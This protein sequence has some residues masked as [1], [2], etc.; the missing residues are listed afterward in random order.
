MA[1]DY[2]AEVEK[3]KQKLAI[4]EGSPYKDGY[5]AQLKQLNTWNKDL[6]DAPTSL[7]YNP[8]TGDSDQKAFEKALKFMLES[9]KLYEKLEYFRGKMNPAQKA[10][11]DLQ[12]QTE[13]KN[14]QLKEKDEKF[15]L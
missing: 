3:L 4:Y 12:K 15:A 13:E 2:K 6:K 14:K 8:D 10:E 7:T 11:L 1:V 9:D 5:L